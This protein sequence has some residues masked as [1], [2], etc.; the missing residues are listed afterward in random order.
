MFIPGG[1]KING[2]TGITR[3][4][5]TKSASAP[6]APKGEFS[7]RFD[8]VSISNAGT[9]NAYAME[10][11]GKLTQ[12][13]RTATSSDMIAALREQVQNGTYEPDPQEIAKKMLL[14]EAI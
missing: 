6:Q 2:S 4:Y 13:V 14:M 5:P 3:G 9:E 11:K 10:L 7:R 12:E 1:A 8:S